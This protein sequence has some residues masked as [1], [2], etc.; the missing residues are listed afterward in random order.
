MRYICNPQQRRTSENAIWEEVLKV[1][2]QHDDID[3][4]YPTSRIYYNQKEGKL[5]TRSKI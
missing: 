3:F 2:A 1:F 4:A 5:G